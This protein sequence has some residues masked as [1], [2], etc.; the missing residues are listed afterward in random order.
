M[1]SLPPRLRS[2]AVVGIE[3]LV[4]VLFL[5]PGRWRPEVLAHLSLATFCM[6]TYTLV[7]VRGF[8]TLLAATTRPEE[9]TARV[10]YVA[11]AAFIFLFSGAVRDWILG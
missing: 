2:S 9:R 4:A 1:L 11:L 5:R 8:G 10:T 6:G 3:A 7:P